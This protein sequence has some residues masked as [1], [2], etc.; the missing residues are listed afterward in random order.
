VVSLLSA[1]GPKS[2]WGEVPSGKT[3]NILLGQSSLAM[4]SGNP[5]N[6]MALNAC[7]ALI[8]WEKA[9]QSIVTSATKRPSV[10]LPIRIVVGVLGICLQSFS[11]EVYPAGIR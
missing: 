3:K 2:D 8:T 11:V 4:H 10:D 1:S 6:E 5:G 7:T 9:G